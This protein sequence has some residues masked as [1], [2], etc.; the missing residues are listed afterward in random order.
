[1]GACLLGSPWE[2]AAT[3]VQQRPWRRPLIRSERRSRK[4]AGRG[5]VTGVWPE[6]RSTGWAAPESGPPALLTGAAVPLERVEP[7]RAGPRLH[8]PSR[9][10]VCRP[11]G[12]G[13][14][15]TYC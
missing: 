13:P 14:V 6:P 11:P 10:R 2:G 4:F 12:P 5:P 15:P 1:M 3:R 7:G 8:A 9:R